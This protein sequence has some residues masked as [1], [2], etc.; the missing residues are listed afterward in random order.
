M[1]AA[2]AAE[3][4]SC[5]LEMST[6]TWAATRAAML[7]AVEIKHGSGQN[8]DGAM[9]GVHFFSVTALLVG[10]RVDRGGDKRDF[11]RVIDRRE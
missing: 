3:A 1:E 7:G 5:S 10:G 4:S 6:A 9:S 8:G 11:F 2:E